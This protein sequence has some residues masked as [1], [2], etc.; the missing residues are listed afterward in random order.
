MSRS[1]VTSVLEGAARMRGNRAHGAV[2]IIERLV[3]MRELV[4]KM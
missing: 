1:D 3:I 4:K 2:G